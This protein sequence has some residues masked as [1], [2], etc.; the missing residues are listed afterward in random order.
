[1]IIKDVM[2]EIGEKLDTIPGVRVL[3]FDADEVQVP[4]GLV[5]LPS[6][7][8]FLGTNQSGLNIIKI[9]ATILVS[10]SDG[11]LIRRD[12]LAP[13]GDHAGPKSVKQALESGPYRSCDDVTVVSGSFT[14]VSI[15]RVDYLGYVSLCDVAGSGRY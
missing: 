9:F 10:K 13:Y 2:D 8:N 11:D 3:P 1:M 4:A 6:N 7:I 15:A 14:V 5:S 12:L